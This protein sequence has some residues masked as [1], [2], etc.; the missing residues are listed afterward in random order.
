MRRASRRASPPQAAIRCVPLISARPSL[1]ASSTGREPRA[2]QRLR[3]RPAPRRRTSRGP[4]R[5]AGSRRARAERGRPRRRPSPRLGTI[6]RTSRSS[7]PS[8]SATSS[9][10]TPEWP[11][12]RLLA[13]SRSMPRTTSAGSGSPTPMACERT[14]LSCSWA[15]SAASIRTEE[16]SPK[17]VVTP[18]TT[19]PC[20]TIASTVSRPRTRRARACGGER[21]GRAAAGDAL[22]FGESERIH[23]DSW[24]GC[25]VAS[26]AVTAAPVI[27]APRGTELSCK[28]WLQEAALRML[29][30]NLDP[31]VAEDPANLV[32]YG[33]TGRAARSW[34]AF[35]AI[36]AT[37]RRL[38][39]DETLLVQSGKPVGVFRTHEMAPR[40][41]IANSLLVPDWADWETFR[42][43]E[44]EGL[45][46]YGQM[47][48]GSWI[49]I[50][51]QGILQGTFETFAAVARKA[52]RRL[53]ARPPGA[54]RRLRRHG[55]RAAARRDDAGR[56]VPRRRR[57]CAPPRAPRRVA[58]PRPRRARSRCRA[59]R[60]RGGA[61]GGRRALD[62]HRRLGGR[63]LPRAARAR[64]RAGHRHRPDERPRSARRLRAGRPLARRRSRA[65][66]ERSRSATSSSSRASMAGHCAAMVEFQERGL[67]GLRLRQQPARRGAHG[68]LRPRLRLP[69]LRRGLRPAALLHGH[70]AVPLGGALGRPRRHRGDRCRRRRALPRERA[71]AALARARAHAHRLPGPAG[72]HLL[73]RLRRAAP[74]RPALQ[75]ARAL[76]RGAARRS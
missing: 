51:T 7:R 27:R 65:A 38:E 24:Y 35:H 66:R 46:M 13:S 68:R 70:R 34:E 25:L 37:L 5:R 11:F 21:R 74:G 49:Y 73:A 42:R 15:A 29:M 16:R 20:A 48:A 39:N 56:R 47:T 33:G 6:G 32:V 3:R 36:V 57:R 23:G 67:G 63:G 61:R 55:R 45:T 50:G 52:L 69:G 43:L 9:G 58:L 2:A 18:Y 19:V 59:A 22:E 4:R 71:P 64:R 12:E 31:E 53:A 54:H 76:G 30:N 28:G 72:A 60:G 62:R 17:P 8:S 1:A 26:R 44:A 75:R 40:V 14:R 10:R 41:L